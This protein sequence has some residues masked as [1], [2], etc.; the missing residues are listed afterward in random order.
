MNYSSLKF[1][2]VCLRV[3][4]KNNKFYFSI[5][6]KSQISI[7]ILHI[8]SNNQLAI[9]IFCNKLTYRLTVS[10]INTCCN[11]SCEKATEECDRPFRTIEA[12]YI[13]WSVFREFKG[14]HAGC[15][16]HWKIKV[17]REFDRDLNHKY[18]THLPFFL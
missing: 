9:W 17:L 15:E 13:N 10:C 2:Q 7:G 5:L 14:Y 3:I 4:I 6:Q 16:F 8:F 1:W 11:W 12:Y 18:C